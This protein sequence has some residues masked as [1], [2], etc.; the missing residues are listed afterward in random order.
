MMASV[1]LFL[2]LLSG[3][4][5]EGSGATAA[6]PPRVVLETSMGRVVL[7][8]FPDKAPKTVENF[9]RYVRAGHYEGTIFHRVV[10]GFVIQGGGFTP[11]M[12]EKSTGPPV[13]NEADNGLQN[14]RGTVAMARTS[15]PH[16][17]R[18]QFFVNLKDN[19]FLDHTAQTP[20]GW[21]YAVFGKVVEGMDVVDAIAGVETGRHGP[22]SDVPKTPVVIQKATVQ[23]E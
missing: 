16:S 21:G 20:Q 13:P 10:A 4:P 23:G 1:L 8:L 7:E 22:F 12:R 9:L 3:G 6:T 14:Q 11:E 2:T 18:A 17:A 19:G 15:D 5:S